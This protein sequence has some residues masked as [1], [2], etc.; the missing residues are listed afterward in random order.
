MKHK[1]FLGIT[2]LMAMI[3]LSFSGNVSAYGS[4]TAKDVV[5]PYAD[6][7]NSDVTMDGKADESGFTTVTID[8]TTAK[9]I[10][11]AFRH[12]A[13]TIHVVMTSENPGWLA[14]GWHN[15]K[16]S[17]TTGAGPM[18]DANII[19][20]G[21]TVRDDTG[22]YA[23]H[24]ADATNNIINSTASVTSSGATFEFLFPLASSDSVDQPLT[25]KE[26]GYFIVAS[27]L[28]GNVD[29]GH[30]GADE[31][32]YLPNV[33]IQSSA[34]EAYKGP[35]GGGSAPFADPAIIVLAL[36]LVAVGVKIKRK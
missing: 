15:S 25:V 7:T 33:Y 30:G 13:D 19:I 4:T 21:T 36:G 6:F 20:G 22:A 23:T 8:F 5:L 27:G 34:G 14:L 11:V 24:S 1:T 16:P 35:S 31:S 28:S 9:S 2:L 10:T 12:N 3:M 32:Y 17:S 29:N 26:W 18:V